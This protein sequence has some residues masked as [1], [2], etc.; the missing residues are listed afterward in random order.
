MNKMNVLMVKPGEHPERVEI[1][2]SLES[3]QD[4]VGGYIQAVYPFDDPIALICNEEGKLYH[5]PTNRGLRDEHGEIYDI[6][7]GNFLIVGL[8]GDN[9]GSL[10]PELMTRYEGLFYHPEVFLNLN[11][12]IYGIPADLA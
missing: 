2:N 12:K 11:G 1:E 8:A 4:A 5:L 9:F 10:S 6:V 7:V 3:L